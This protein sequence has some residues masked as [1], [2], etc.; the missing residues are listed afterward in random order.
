MSKTNEILAKLIDQQFGP[1]KGNPISPPKQRMMRKPNKEHSD[2]AVIKSRPSPMKM[3]PLRR[4]MRQ[5][6]DDLLEDEP[7]LRP[8]PIEKPPRREVV[9][10][11][12]MNREMK[13]KQQ[14][15]PLEP[16]KEAPRVMIDPNLRQMRV[17]QRERIRDEQREI[18]RREQEMMRHEQE[19]MRREHEMMTQKIKREHKEK[20]YEQERLREE[21]REKLEL[22][23]E[24]MRQDMERRQRAESERRQYEDRQE[25]RRFEL[26][27]IR[28]ENQGRSQLQLQAM[29]QY[30]ADRQ[31][32]R[33]HMTESKRMKYKDKDS[34]RQHELQRMRIE[35]IE[36][37]TRAHIDLRQQALREQ[38]AATDRRIRLQEHNR[39]L[40]QLHQAYIS[41]KNE[42]RLEVVFKEFGID[43]QHTN[44]DDVYLSPPVVESYMA[45]KRNYT[46]AHL[47]IGV[48]GI[49]HQG[50][51]LHITFI[52]G[53][54]RTI[55][56]DGQ[57]FRM[58]RFG[59]GI[60]V[61]RFMRYI[62][63]ADK[64]EY[65]PN[66]PSCP[67]CDVS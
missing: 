4:E 21:R 22:E 40:I 30:V 37:L 3:K 33:K 24:R 45:M 7:S 15:Q 18:M 44:H 39:E 55:P 20:K 28:A 34:Q 56:I 50:D 52:D 36:P 54:T 48:K 58:E 46:Y 8:V 41:S 59:G 60:V 16:V 13:R 31:N 49:E 14:Y 17:E 65:C 63:L 51:N 61:I 32:E 42:E 43:T 57:Y 27:R 12:A 47:C 62:T 6:S 10:K 2:D 5:L 64:R 29:E 25:E 38:E 66:C 53:V 9:P 11:P 19:M 35:H 26:Q 23:R 1:S 67:K